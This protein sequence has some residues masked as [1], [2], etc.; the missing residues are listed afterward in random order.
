MF[1]GDIDLRNVSFAPRLKR[2]QRLSI[3]R[4]RQLC[5]GPGSNRLNENA[6]CQLCAD[7]EPGVA[8]LANDV[9]LVTHQFYLLFFTEAHF[10][11][12]MRN[13]GRGRELFDANGCASHD[14]AEW[15]KERLFRAAIFA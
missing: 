6:F 1:R 11:Q 7:A 12:A 4:H 8:D 9:G 13:F 3:S 15:A 10:T 14:S 5:A 2:T